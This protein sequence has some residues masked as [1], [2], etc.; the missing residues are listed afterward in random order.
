[1]W[2]GFRK[3]EKFTK[4]ERPTF[5]AREN[6]EKLVVK[7]EERTIFTDKQLMEKLKS[8]LMNE[9]TKEFDLVPKTKK[10]FKVFSTRDILNKYSKELCE[11][12]KVEN[13]EK[14][15]IRIGNP[16]RKCINLHLG[17]E[18]IRGITDLEEQKLYCEELERFIVE[19]ILNKK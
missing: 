13:T 4:P 2:E 11:K 5:Q 7:T 15:L 1:M 14:N 9:L 3:E 18:D 10:D 8:E 17:L 19:Y 16:I 6:N 12:A